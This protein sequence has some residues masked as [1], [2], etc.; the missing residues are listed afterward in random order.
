VIG[1]THVDLDVGKDALHGIRHHVLGGMTD[2]LSGG[3]ILGRDDLQRGIGPERSAEI[4]ELSIDAPR[5]GGAGQFL[6]DAFGDVEN[7]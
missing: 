1:A 3:G 2:H 6:A 4:D 5:Q 7:G